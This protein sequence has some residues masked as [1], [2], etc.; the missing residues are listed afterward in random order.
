MCVRPRPPAS[1]GLR[2]QPFDTCLATSVGT[3]GVWKISTSAPGLMV[4]V[5]LGGGTSLMTNTAATAGMFDEILRTRALRTVFQ[6]IVRLENGNTEGY[7]ALVRGPA[8]SPL[9]SA[10]ALLA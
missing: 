8:G 10:A 9:E 2:R 6:R 4:P 7:E 3:G 5:V 1:R